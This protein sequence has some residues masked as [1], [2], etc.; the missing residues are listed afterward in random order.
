MAYFR[1]RPY[2]PVAVRRQK[3]QRNIKKLMKKK[4]VIEPVEIVGRTIAKTFWGKSW[5]SHLENFSDY[6]NRLP[7]GRSYVRNGL[8]CHLDIEKGRVK[9]I[10]SG[11][12]LYN[13]EV[14][15][16]S[17]PSAKWQ[18]IK[19]QCAGQIGSLLELLQ[20]KFSDRVMEV[21]TNPEKGLFPLAKEIKF[22][23]DCPDWAEMCKHIAA[24]LYGVGAR[25]DQSPEL[26]FKLRG[27]DHE[28]LIDLEVDFSKQG[29]KKGKKQRLADQDLSE[30]FGVELD[31]DIVPENEKKRSAHR[32]KKTIKTN[33]GHKREKQ[34]RVRIKGKVSSEKR[35]T[36]I[37][38]AAKAT[39]PDDVIKL[40]ETAKAIIRLRKKLKLS[41]AEFAGLIKVS[42]VTVNNWE[43][44]KG[45]L[46]MHTRTAKALENVI[47]L[48]KDFVS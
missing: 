35:K 22:T 45:K 18:D 44:K 15:I 25:L 11:S 48:Q 47:L 30:I 46:N 21:V 36:K 31:N 40:P 27:V 12:S 6:E 2:V 13:V 28:E 43:K 38:G 37:R 3:G 24:V 7:R 23:C 10:V 19:K 5:C 33:R 39:K 4:I 32:V 1:W 29:K 14:N 26:L 41:K 34:K 42:V 9:A 8:V 17:F 16:K 20:G